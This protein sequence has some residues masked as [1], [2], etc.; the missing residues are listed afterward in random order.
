MDSV[1]WLLHQ[2]RR[3]PLLTPEQEITLGRQVQEWL[4]LQ[5][6]TNK[7]ELEAKRYKQ[8]LRAYHTFFNSNIRL[9]VKCAGWFNRKPGGL[10]YE[11]LIS[12]GMIG[13]H[14]AIKKYEPAKGYKF[15]TYAVWWI[16]QSINR[17]IDSKSAMIYMSANAHQLTRRIYKY[18]NEEELRTGKRPSM[19]ELAVKFKTTVIN[20]RH[21]LAHTPTLVSLDAPSR[22]TEKND[23]ALL[24]LIEDP[25][26]KLEVDELSDLQELLPALLAD[27]PPTDQDIVRRRHLLHTP[28]TYQVLADDYGLSRERIRQLHTRALLSLRQKLVFRGVVPD[29][30]PKQQCA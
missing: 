13:L 27:L 6:V 26:S 9:V 28:D 14:S 22:N 17:A 3:Y 12:E 18:I 1:D 7:T 16:R 21:Y 30:V 24:D 11:D 8:G 19:D 23:T 29:A 5:D 25:S 2:A 15:S 4:A 20:L 10:P